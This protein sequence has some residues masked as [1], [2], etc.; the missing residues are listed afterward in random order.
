MHYLTDKRVKEVFR[1]IPT[2]ETERLILRR[3]TVADSS[4]MYEYSKDADVTKYLTWAPHKSEQETFR[5]LKLVEKKYA[6]GA[7]WDFGIEYKENSKFI[8]TCGF[9]S[10]DYNMHTAEIGYVIAPG[11]HG[12]GIA[13]E[14]ARAVMKFGFVVFDLE[15]ICARFLQGNDASE[16]VMQ[17]MNMTYVDTY[18]NSLFI[19]GEYKTVV[20]YKITAKEFFEKTN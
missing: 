2:I 15:S 17:K 3:I 11:Y 7:F 16:R 18:K 20:E 8:G 4:D 10:F 1:N 12:M 13:C 5:Y 9:T 19:K 14:A 6:Q